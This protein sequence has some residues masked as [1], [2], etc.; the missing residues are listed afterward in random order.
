VHHFRNWK[1]CS[2]SSRVRGFASRKERPRGRSL[3]WQ[4]P[5]GPAL[6]RREDEEEGRWRGGGKGER[7]L[8]RSQ[9]G[10]TFEG[11]RAR[12]GETGRDRGARRRPLP[13]TAEPPRARVRERTGEE[14]RE[15]RPAP[16]RRDR[17]LGVGAQRRRKGKMNWRATV[18]LLPSTAEP[19]GR[20]VSTYR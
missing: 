19:S 17:A 14:G 2:P 1:S 11:R 7:P 5:L 12:G 20:H 10:R 8:S 16:P 3:A 18:G 15:K 4:N 13:G 6:E 9:S